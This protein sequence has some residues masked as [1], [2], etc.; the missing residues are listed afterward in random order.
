MKTLPAMG[1]AQSV[2][3]GI[4][5]AHTLRTDE[6]AT[7][8]V[9]TI[10]ARETSRWSSFTSPGKWVRTTS[11]ASSA[12]HS[13]TGVM[14]S[15]RDNVSRR[16]S[17]SPTMTSRSTPKVSQARWA[18]SACCATLPWRLDAPS[19]STQTHTWS[20]RAA[21][22]A[23]VPPAPSVSS[24]GCAATVSIRMPHP[25]SPRTPSAHVTARGIS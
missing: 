11:G 3:D 6:P 16:W 1:G 5:N 25:R 21:W 18:H 17:G 23:I 24:S 9:A 13:S 15:S 2:D 8:R 14:T 4:S 19:A 20:P 22:Y 12:M 10:T 7:G